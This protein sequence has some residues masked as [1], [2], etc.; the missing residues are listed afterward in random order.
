MR[1]NL[2]LGGKDCVFPAYVRRRPIISIIVPMFPHIN[3]AL[4]DLNFVHIEAIL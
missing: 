3:S 2:S 1:E 4:S